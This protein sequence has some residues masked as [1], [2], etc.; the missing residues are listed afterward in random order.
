MIGRRMRRR[1]L[2]AAVAT[3][4]MLTPVVI[5]ATASSAAA[6]QTYYVPVTKTWTVYGHGFGHGRGLSQYGAEGA[7][8]QGLHYGKILSFYYPGTSLGSVRGR[9]RVLVSA[10]TTSDLQVRPHRGLKVRDLRDGASWKLPVHSHLDRWRMIPIP[11]GTTAVQYHNST[12]WHRW[13]IP[14][15]R[16]SFRSDG[17]FRAH[18]A[19]TLLIPAGSDVTGKR[20]RGVLRLVRPYAGATTRDTVNVL[21]MD[22]YVQ[23]VVP[24]EMPPS[25]HGQALRAQAVAARTYATWQR[26]QNPDRYYQLCDTTACQ[27]YGGV[28]AEQSSTNSAVQA[29]AGRVLTF[30]GG[31]ALTEFSA[32]SGGWTA[33]GGTAYLPAKRDPYDGFNGNAVHDWTTTISAS[34]LEASHPEVGRLIDVRVTRRDGHGAWNGRVQQVVLEGS[35]GTAYVTGDDF[36]W[37]YGLRSNWFT[38]AP[39]PIMQR[40]RDIGGRKSVVGRPVSGEFAVAT[41]SAQ[42]FSSGRIYWSAGHGAKELLG[43]VLSAYRRWGG[44][45][46]NLRWPATGPMDA[47]NGG[48]KVRFVGGMIYS[49]TGTGARVLYGRILERWGHAGAVD[50]WLGYPTTS[51]Y[52]ITGGL[53]ARFQHGTISWDRS[54]DTFTVTRD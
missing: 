25:W 9:V 46:S 23:G 10:D 31:P 44:P 34:T 16:G 17:E 43:P 24:Y 27:V 33:S 20:Y 39:T 45:T 7:A 37:L 50:S 26:Q 30:N 36:R 19:L 2:V 28:A 13:T 6:D 51:I 14:D 49:H 35:S 40:W 5:A 41:G 48:H 12:G 1:P 38:I 42:K 29:T 3:A 54:S 32:S 15:G 22:D 53:A 21:H 11:N 4:A 52:A 18:G 47:S 8:R